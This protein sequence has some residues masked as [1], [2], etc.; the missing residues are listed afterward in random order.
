[1]RRLPTNFGGSYRQLPTH[2]RGSYRRLPT[3]I[4]IS[5]EQL[6]TTF[7]AS[8]GRSYRQLSDNLR[9]NFLV[10]TNGFRV[11]MGSY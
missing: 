6:A 1:M 10:V 2:F 4:A 9:T 7:G 11:F 8:Y 5:Y 3:N